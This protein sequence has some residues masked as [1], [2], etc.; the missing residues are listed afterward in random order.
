[1]AQ[2]IGDWMGDYDKTLH[3][4]N[5]LGDAV[6]MLTSEGKGAE[7]IVVLAKQSAGWAANR[8]KANLWRL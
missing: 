3:V 1:M 6:L 4:E 8:P 7:G 2:A 5:G